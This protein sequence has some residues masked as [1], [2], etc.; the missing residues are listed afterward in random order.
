MET[1]ERL[2]K[3]AVRTARCGGVQRPP[4]RHSPPEKTVGGKG[5]VAFRDWIEE[6]EVQSVADACL[7]RDIHKREEQEAADEILAEQWQVLEDAAVDHGGPAKDDFGLYACGARPQGQVDQQRLH[8]AA[9][10][11]PG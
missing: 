3:A 4:E 8:F 6:E 5:S 1:K 2:D 9:S 11:K 7:A 10:I